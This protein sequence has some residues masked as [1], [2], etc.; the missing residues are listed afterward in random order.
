MDEIDFVWLFCFFFGQLPITRLLLQIYPELSEPK[1]RILLMVVFIVS[2][3]YSHVFY[4]IYQSLHMEYEWH[5]AAHDLERA[6][7]A[8]KGVSLRAHPIH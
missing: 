2:L 3:A 1:K 7:Q 5:S 6:V 4:R 8:F